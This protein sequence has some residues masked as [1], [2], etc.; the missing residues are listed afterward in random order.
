MKFSKRVATAI[1]TVAAFVGLTAAPALAKPSTSSSWTVMDYPVSGQS[2]TSRP[3]TVTGSDVSFNFVNGVYTALLVTSDPSLTGDLSHK[4]GLTA[5]LAVTNQDGT[6][7]EQNGG[8]CSPDYQFVRFY[9]ATPGNAST[10][11]WW[12]YW[13]NQVNLNP[14]TNT[15]ATLTVSFDPANWSDLNGMQ[16]SAEPTGFANA[17]KK[18]STIGLSFGGGCFFENGLTLAGG[19][20]NTAT[21]TNGSMGFTP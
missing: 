1:L 2:L 8:G 20:S 19:T 4:T 13:G 18:V 14:Q 15:A 6:F 5:N 11:I 12:S 16:G 21:F 10:H 17:L 9:F 3:A 7:Q